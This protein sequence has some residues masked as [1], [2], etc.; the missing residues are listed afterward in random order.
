MTKSQARV[1]AWGNPERFSV[2]KDEA[3][4]PQMKSDLRSMFEGRSSSMVMN[5]DFSGKDYTTRSYAKKRWA[6]DRGFER[7]KYQGNTDA[8]RYKMEPWF[9]RKQA[10]AEGRAAGMNGQA[11]TTGQYD[12]TTAIEQGANRLAR[13]SDAETDVRRRVFREPD[14]IDWKEQQGLGVK[15]TNKMLGRSE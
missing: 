3:G 12:K 4:N 14:I 1:D 7:K 5:K 11:F 9:V 10:L 15:D 2:G 8:S 6:G 13:P